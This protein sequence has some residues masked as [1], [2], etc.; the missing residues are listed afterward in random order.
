MSQMKDITGERFGKLVVVSRAANNRRGNAMWNCVCDC[1]NKSIASGQNL[2]SGAVKSCGCT[3]TEKN[4]ERAKHGMSGT[5]LYKTWLN[6]R[7]RCTDKKSKS[8]KDYGGRGIYVCEE[9][10][11][12][13]KSFY[14]WAIANGYIE[15]LTIERINNDG[16]YSPD[17]CRWA[18]RKEQSNNR[19]RC[20]NIEYL[21][22]TQNLTQWCNELN[23][24]YK[25]IHCRMYE[26]GMAFE[27]AIKEPL[28]ESRS[29]KAK[30]E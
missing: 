19:R 4:R 24:D 29:H 22:R 5:K 21:G 12:D 10:K 26:R 11:N 27:D 1:G 15:G 28:M 13:Y 16:P 30:K 8:F 23:L 9:W 14:D 2:R 3:I 7:R 17:N 18:T 6:M 25:F 20:I